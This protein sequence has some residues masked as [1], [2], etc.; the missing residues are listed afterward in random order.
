MTSPGED[1]STSIHNILA[2]LL[3]DG[4]MC[5]CDVHLYSFKGWDRWSTVKSREHLKKNPYPFTN[6]VLIYWRIPQECVHFQCPGSRRN[7]VAMT[8]NKEKW[9]ESSEDMNKGAAEMDEGSGER[10]ER[11]RDGWSEEP[12]C[13]GAQQQRET[14]HRCTEEIGE[15]LRKKWQVK[16]LGKVG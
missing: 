16:K 15:R 10:Q 3:Y 4:W 11:D 5:W 9:R 7:L 6:Y 1:G 13:T 2:S 8:R 12:G 14:S